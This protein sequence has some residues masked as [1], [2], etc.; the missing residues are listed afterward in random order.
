[1]LFRVFSC[2]TLTT[3]VFFA[4]HLIH[5]PELFKERVLELNASDDRG[6]QAIREKVRLS[7]LLSYAIYLLW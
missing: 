3:E 6:I 2:I 5:S 1:M 4:L 7:E